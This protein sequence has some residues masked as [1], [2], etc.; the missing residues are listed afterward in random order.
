M[1]GPNLERRSGWLEAVEDEVYAADGC[2]RPELLKDLGGRAR[3]VH[4]L[5]IFE[6]PAV[7][8]DRRVDAP[9][10]GEGLLT[11]LGG[12]EME[13]VL[14]CDRERV[15][16]AARRLERGPHLGELFLHL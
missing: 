6:G 9:L 1:R 5:E 3:Q 10:L 4:L 11:V 2:P 7:S 15:Q 12:N 14:M 8:H 16:I 13:E